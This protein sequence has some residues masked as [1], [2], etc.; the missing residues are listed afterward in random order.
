MLQLRRGLRA[1]GA[2]LRPGLIPARGCWR[3]RALLHSGP[4]ACMPPLDHPRPAT[5]PRPCPQPGRQAPVRNH[6]ALQ[7]LGCAE[8]RAVPAALAGA[9]AC[10]PGVP[11]QQAEPALL[12]PRPH[13][14][15]PSDA[16][17]TSPHPT[18]PRQTSSSTRTWSRRARSCSRWT[19]RRRGSSWTRWAGAAA[20]TGGVQRRCRVRRLKQRAGAVECGKLPWSGHRRTAARARRVRLRDHPPACTA[21]APALARPPARPPAGLPGGLWRRAGGA[22]AGARGALPRRRLLLRH[23]GGGDRPRVHRRPG[24]AAVSPGASSG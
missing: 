2:G 24:G 11:P 17:S 14:L 13:Q 20:G 8:C 16:L 10:M 15:S 23:L 22:G 7:P 3:R 9:P 21:L 1:E 12:P 18:R 5:S 6:L 19:S 4:R